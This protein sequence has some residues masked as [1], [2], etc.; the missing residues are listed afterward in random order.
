MDELEVLNSYGVLTAPEIAEILG[1]N[2]VSVS[3]NIRFYIKINEVKTF[4][5]INRGTKKV[6][7]FNNELYKDI[8]QDKA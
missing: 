3:R 8:F 7:Y 6:F 1:K 5:F 4:S 2:R